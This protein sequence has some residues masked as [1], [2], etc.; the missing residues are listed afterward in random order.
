M[1]LLNLILKLSMKTFQ[2]IK[3]NVIKWS[4]KFS[5]SFQNNAFIKFKTLSHESPYEPS[6]CKQCCRIKSEQHTNAKGA[7]I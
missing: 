5:P 3:L 7:S 1:F 2:T 4:K 6:I